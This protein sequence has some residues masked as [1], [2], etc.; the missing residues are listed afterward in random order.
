MNDKLERLTAIQ[1]IQLVSDKGTFKEMSEVYPF[2]NPLQ[3]SGYFEKR[4]R[5]RSETGLDEAVVTGYCRIQEVPCILMVMDSYFM[6]GSMG[7]VVGE[8]IS[9]GF[10]IAST[11]K[12]PVVCF[13]ASSGARMQ[14][15]AY[16]LFQM[17]KT[18]GA[19]RIHHKK[20]QLFISIITDPTLGGV[21][22]SFAS[23]ADI[24]LAEPGVVFG[25]TGRRIIQN[26][27]GKE[28]AKGFQS[29]E[30]AL[31]H[32]AIDRIVPREE[33]KDTLGVLLT[34]HKKK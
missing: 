22:A 25:F 15:G 20:R 14:E 11:R 3:F 7:S 1:R 8:K 6:M 13:C 26:T 2:H 18:S 32:G 19:A 23:L 4:N 34:W 29:A 28:L 33:M 12:L 16:S 30:Y 27:M 17:A 10:E 9:R 5:A 24:I 31:D 21:S